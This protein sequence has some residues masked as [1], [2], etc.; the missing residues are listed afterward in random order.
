MNE[1]FHLDRMVDGF[2]EFKNGSHRFIH[3]GDWRQVQLI[4]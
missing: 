2:I 4:G 1:T 3:G